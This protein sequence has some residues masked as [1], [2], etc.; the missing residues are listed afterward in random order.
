MAEK[1]VEVTLDELKSSIVQGER[2]EIRGLRRKMTEARDR[3][4]P[5]DESGGPDPARMNRPLQ[6]REGP[7]QPGA[8]NRDKGHDHL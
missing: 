7:R 5:Q 6:T 3:A 2:I 1:A 8:V 4:E